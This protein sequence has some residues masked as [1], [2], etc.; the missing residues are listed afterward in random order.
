VLTRKPSEW[1]QTI[2]LLLENDKDT[3]EGKL[4]VITNNPIDAINNTDFIILCG[5]VSAY[6]SMLDNIRSALIK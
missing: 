2:K 4:N 5:P 3:I 6:P 1:S